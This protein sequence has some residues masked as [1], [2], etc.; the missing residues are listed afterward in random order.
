MGSTSLQPAPRSKAQYIDNCR[1]RITVAPLCYITVGVQ[2]RSDFP[3]AS[4]V[5]TICAQPDYR[6]CPLQPFEIYQSNWERVSLIISL[7]HGPCP[8]SSWAPPYNESSYL[9]LLPT[10]V[11]ELQFLPGRRNI[12]HFV[13]SNMRRFLFTC[14]SI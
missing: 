14:S 11:R 3:P 5:K 13:L 10:C 1:S 4:A 6:N 8:G 7:F 9:T 2:P 12:K